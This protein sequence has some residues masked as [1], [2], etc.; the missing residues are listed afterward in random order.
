MT[1]GEIWWVDFGLPFGS[2][3]QGRC[4]AIV[5][6]NDT[7]NASRILTTVVIPLTTN[8]LL[9]EHKNNVFLDKSVTKLPKDSVV[10]TPQVGVVDKS[11][12]IEKVSKLSPAI[13]IEIS[14]ALSDLLSLP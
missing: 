13:M 6:Q 4:P 2:S 10:L 12:L 5:I 3:P 8:L 9:A 1:R 14:H 11:W 7:F